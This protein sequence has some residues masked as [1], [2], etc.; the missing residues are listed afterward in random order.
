[1]VDEHTVK[2]WF[3]NVKSE[4]KR[5]SS[6]RQ[7]LR[8]QQEALTAISPNMSGM[9]HTSGVSD[10]VG[11]GV[12]GCIDQQRELEQE[13]EKLNALK[14]EAIRRAQSMCVDTECA[15]AIIA[16]YVTGLTHGQIAGKQN[17]YGGNVVRKRIDRGCAALAEIWECFT[18]DDQN[19]G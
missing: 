9:P 6:L 16:Y 3:N 4:I 10:K 19:K 7:R 2:K 5:V 12:V 13:I 8:E 11:N 15:Q 14:M 18:N 17:V 1:M